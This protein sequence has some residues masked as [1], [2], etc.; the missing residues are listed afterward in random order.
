MLSTYR[1]FAATAAYLGV[2]EAQV[3]AWVDGED[4][5]GPLIARKFPDGERLIHHDDLEAFRRPRPLQRP[6]STGISALCTLAAGLKPSAEQ[7]TLQ[8][9]SAQN[10]SVALAGF[11]ARRGTAATKAFRAL[12]D[13]ADI[14]RQAPR[15]FTF[16]SPDPNTGCHLWTGCFDKRHGYGYFR[17]WPQKVV[18]AAHR[19]A[20]V[21][22]NGEI[23]E[24][25]DIDHAVCSNRW[26]VN[27]E[28]L[29][30]VTHHENIIR[31]DERRAV[32]GLPDNCAAA[33]EAYRGTHLRLVR[34]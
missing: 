22:A 30:A 18:A 19:V 31:R 28:H 29:E 2:T 20:W 3:T 6:V 8:V 15:F 33:R 17:L 34:P 21:I 11:G 5:N 26:C 16:V 24:R 12:A 14:R 10:H 27:H 32:L 7:R 25:V 9:A 1:T 4:G 23:P 13:V